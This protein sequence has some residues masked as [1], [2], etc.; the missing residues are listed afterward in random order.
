MALKDFLQYNNIKHIFS[1]PYHPASNVEAEWDMWTFKEAM[2]VAKGDSGW[3]EM[4][5]S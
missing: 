4:K 2:Q 5:F 3:W 1:A